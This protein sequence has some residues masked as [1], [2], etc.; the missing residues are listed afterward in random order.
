MQTSLHLA[1]SALNA[2]EIL[3]IVIW[4]IAWLVVLASALLRSDLDPVTR[5]TWVL[6]IILVP[7]FGVILYCFIGPKRPL[8]PKQAPAREPTTCMSCGGNIPNDQS[9]CSNCGWS[10]DNRSTSDNA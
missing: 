4:T 5:L 7:I 6:V 3:A 2:P 8:V 10:Y 1:S 9:V